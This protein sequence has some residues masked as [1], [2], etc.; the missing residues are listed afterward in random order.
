MTKLIEQTLFGTVN[1]ID[2]A[3]ARLKEAAKMAE[4]L[5]IPVLYVAD[6]GGKDSDVII[7]LAEIAEVP[8]EVSHNHTT[9]DHPI[10]V[11]FI[12]KRKVEAVFPQQ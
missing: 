8:Y 10:T 7:K 2:K 4:V 12:R 9:A 5:E 11:K 1:Y 6:S 3:V